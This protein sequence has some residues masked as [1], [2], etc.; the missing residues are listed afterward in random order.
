MQILPNIKSIKQERKAKEIQLAK[1]SK[2]VRELEENLTAA[3]NVTIHEE[4]PLRIS[5]NGAVIEIHSAVQ[6]STRSAYLTRDTLDGATPEY[7]TVKGFRTEGAADSK[8]LATGTTRRNAL[9][10]G[11]DFVAVGKIGR[12]AAVTAANAEVTP[13]KR[14]RPRKVAVTA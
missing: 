10:V 11:K 1:L 9:R 2:E 13:K 14:G 8:M 6:D 7:W 12:P 4:F 3:E 5:E